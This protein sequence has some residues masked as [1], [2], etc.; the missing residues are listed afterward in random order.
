MPPPYSH[1]LS[2]EYCGKIMI[3]L[4]S[5]QVVPSK[6]KCLSQIGLSWFWIGLSRV[7]LSRVESRSFNLKNFVV[8]KF[9]C[10]IKARNRKRRLGTVTG[11][12]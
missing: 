5:D 8:V 10:F 3:Q 9:L 1:C 11:F 7:E 12:I 6:E 4:A 2:Y